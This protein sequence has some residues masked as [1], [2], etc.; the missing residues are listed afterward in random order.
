MGFTSITPVSLAGIE[1]DVDL[2]P[3]QP[4]EKIRIPVDAGDMV[5]A[6]AQGGRVGGDVGFAVEF[7]ERIR[8]MQ[9]VGGRVLL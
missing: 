6:G 8:R 2:Q 5:P 3:L 9:A 1:A 4:A 7:G